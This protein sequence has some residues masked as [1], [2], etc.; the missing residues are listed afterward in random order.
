MSTKK[1]LMLS[2]LIPVGLALALPVAAMGPGGAGGPGGERPSFTEL[3]VTVFSVANLTNRRQTFFT[4]VPL[5]T[6][7]QTQCCVT[8]M[9]L[10]QQLS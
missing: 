10:C 5:F 1:A 9:I 8:R 6:T 3:D 7:W 2:V 4:N